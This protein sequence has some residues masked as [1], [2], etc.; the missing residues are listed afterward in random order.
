MHILKTVQAYYPFQEKGGPVVK[1][2]ALSRSLSLRG[3][4]VTV[5]SPDLGLSGR[6]HLKLE[7][8]RCRWGSRVKEAGV[9]AIYVPTLVR[10]RALTIN[11]RVIDFCSSALRAFDIVHFYGL[12]DLLGPIVG[13]YCRKYGIRQVIEPMGMRRP[14]DRSINIKKFGHRSIG[15][16]FWRHADRIVATSE[17]ERQELLKM[18]FRVRSL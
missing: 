14:I 9:E 17:L 3:H 13:F 11:P 2:R 18:G 10:Y 7:I 8:E 6:G 12:Y 16:G 15:R 1:V 5:V 4:A